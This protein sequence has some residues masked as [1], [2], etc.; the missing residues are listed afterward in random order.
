MDSAGPDHDKQFVIEVTVL[1]HRCGVG[2]GL[3][4]QEASQ[5]A[6]NRALASLGQAPV[7]D[8]PDDEELNAAWPVA[9]DVADEVQAAFASAA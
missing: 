8:W 7:T 5:A 9:G 6:A 1:G 2:R 4:K 3:S